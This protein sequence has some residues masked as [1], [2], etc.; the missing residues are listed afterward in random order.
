MRRI[1]NGIL[2]VNKTGCQW[3]LVSK[4][5]GHWNTIY[6]D[7]QRWRRDG[8]WARVMETLRQRERRGLGRTPEPAAG[9]MDSQSSKT[10][11]Q[12]KDIGFDGNKTIKGRKRHLLVDTLG[13]ILAVGVAD[14]GTDDR[15]GLVA[16]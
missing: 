11:T 6:G 7:F 15:L 8:V 4:E 16:L 5:L 1:V 14:A 12:N 9:S 2:Y 10:A 13:L 3:R